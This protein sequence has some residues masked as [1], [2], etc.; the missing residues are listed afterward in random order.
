MKLTE[1]FI[2][3]FVDC[4]FFCLPRVSSTIKMSEKVKLTKFSTLRG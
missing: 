1:V 4:N 3:E 2:I